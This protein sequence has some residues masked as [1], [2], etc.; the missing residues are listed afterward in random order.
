MGRVEGNALLLSV[1]PSQHLI[2]GDMVAD[3]NESF[4]DATA[5][6]KGDIALDLRLYIAG[7]AHLGAELGGLGG[8]STHTCRRVPGRGWRQHASCEGHSNCKAPG[9]GWPPYPAGS[10]RYP[11][12]NVRLVID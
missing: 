3:V 2:R 4:D 1:N 9:C 7:Q 11:R 10:H 12:C 6:A 5:D 8:H